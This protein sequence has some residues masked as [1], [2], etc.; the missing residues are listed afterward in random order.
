[1]IILRSSHFKKAYKQLPTD[2]QSRFKQKLRLFIQNPKHPSLRVKKLQ[3][4]R[5]IFEARVT[6]SY[7]WTFHLIKGGV[8][9]RHIG[10]H[11]ILDQP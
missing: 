3:A 6:K 2:I 4:T 9:L 5:D 10:T 7:R 8:K 1:M 11:K